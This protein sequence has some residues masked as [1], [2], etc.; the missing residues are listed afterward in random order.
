MIFAISMHLV[1]E[2]FIGEWQIAQ[3]GIET[4]FYLGS[5]QEYPVFLRR[6]PAPLPDSKNVLPNMKDLAFFDSKIHQK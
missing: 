1:P 4:F 3:R 5:V 2:P 6:N